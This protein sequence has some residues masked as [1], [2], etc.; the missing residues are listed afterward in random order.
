MSI[1][2]KHLQSHSGYSDADA[3][4]DAGKSS[5]RRD[6]RRLSAPGHVE[7]YVFSEGYIHIVSCVCDICVYVVADTICILNNVCDC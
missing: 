2:V 3:D 1:L 6:K 4:A 5:A 7:M